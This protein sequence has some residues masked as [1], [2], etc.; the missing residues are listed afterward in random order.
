M[1]NHRC[2]VP[3]RADLGRDR[4]GAYAGAADSSPRYTYTTMPSNVVFVSGDDYRRTYM[5]N[6][7][8]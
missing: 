7:E 1:E 8:T 5:V 4:G 2:G 3:R 6:G